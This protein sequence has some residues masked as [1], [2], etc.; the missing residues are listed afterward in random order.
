MLLIKQKI[1]KK[2][3][4]KNLRE[5]LQELISLKKKLKIVISVEYIKSK[6]INLHWA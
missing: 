1:T 4:K 5:L 2:T 3:L 6:P